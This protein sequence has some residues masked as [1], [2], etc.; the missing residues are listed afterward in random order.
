M[1]CNE[2]TLAGRSIHENPLDQVIAVLVT[3]NY[4]SVSIVQATVE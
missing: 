4:L 3:G 1:G 2:L